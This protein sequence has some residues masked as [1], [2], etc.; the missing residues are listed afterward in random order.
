VGVIFQE[1]S[2]Y[3]E[4]TTAEYDAFLVRLDVTGLTGAYPINF[5]VSKYT[6]GGA[7]EAARLNLVGKGWSISDGG[8]V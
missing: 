3:P 6:I 1:L 7:G 4:M 2:H 5:G 8:G